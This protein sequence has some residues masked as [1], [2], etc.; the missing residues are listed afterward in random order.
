MCTIGDEYPCYTND[1][2]TT[3]FSDKNP[4]S[5]DAKD[6]YVFAGI[7]FFF[8]CFGI[9]M[10][11]LLHYDRGHTIFFCCNCC[12]LR[13]D[14]CCRFYN[15]QDRRE[16]YEKVWNERMS[17]EQKC[18]YYLRNNGILIAVPNDILNLISLYGD[19]VEQN[20]SGV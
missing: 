7:M 6:M 13:S 5:N 18:D 1:V 10:G 20:K 9:M 19:G 11:P 3:V 15:G 17:F 16:Y 14:E 12:C 4:Y 2:C 8:A